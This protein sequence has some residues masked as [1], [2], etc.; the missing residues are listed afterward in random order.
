MLRE[1]TFFNKDLS[2][3][4]MDKKDRCD[5]LEFYFMSHFGYDNNTY[6]IFFTDVSECK[7]FS[8]KYIGT[9]TKPFVAIAQ[10]FQRMEFYPDIEPDFNLMYVRFHPSVFE[11][12]NCDD[13]FLR[14]FDNMTDENS[15]FDLTCGDNK[16]L[17]PIIQL[18]RDSLMNKYGRYNVES[19][20]TSLITQLTVLY[21]KNHPKNDVDST[22]LSVKLMNYIHKHYTGKLTYDMICQKFFISVPSINK[23]VKNYT[24]MTFGNYINSLRLEDAQKMMSENYV[25]VHKAAELCG[26]SSYNA[27]YR[28]YKKYFGHSPSD[29]KSAQPVYYPFDED[30]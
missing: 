8:G 19:A 20:C 14:V 21:D 17:M 22:N 23:I 26:F 12:N 6:K 2:V 29:D 16:T 4:F 1:Y 15:I 7:I 25:P 13:T 28:A 18:I 3:I 24:G 27:F 5:Q 11:N 9:H 10:P 30:K